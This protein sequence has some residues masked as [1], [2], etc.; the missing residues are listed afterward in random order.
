MTDTPQAYIRLCDTHTLRHTYVH[1]HALRAAALSTSCLPSRFGKHQLCFGADAFTQWRSFRRKLCFCQVMCRGAHFSSFY[2][3][4]TF[5]ESS[6]SHVQESLLSSGY[7]DA[8]SPIQHTHYCTDTP[9]E[10][11]ATRLSDS[12]HAL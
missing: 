10:R 6:K 5:T 3:P 7:F 2:Q 9:F 1:T 8:H 4:V 11:T 12:G